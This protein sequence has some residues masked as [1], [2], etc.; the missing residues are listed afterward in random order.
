ML[1]FAAVRAA[2][3]KVD[4]T[5]GGVHDSNLFR[6]SAP[7][8]AL[9]T[10]GGA[11]DIYS[12]SAGVSITSDH[13]PL[14]IAAQLAATRS[15]FA[16]NKALANTGYAADVALHYRAPRASVDVDG[17]VVRRLANFEDL[18]STTSGSLQTL[19]G[20]TLEAT[21][22]VLG[23]V[24]LI[25]GAGFQRSSNSNPALAIADYNR[26]SAHGGI[27]YYSPTGNILAIEGSMVRATG[28]NDRQSTVGG[29]LFA[30]RASFSEQTAA[31]HLFYSPSVLWQIDTRIGYT[32]HKDKSGVA[33]DYS[34]LTGRLDAR[35]VP[36]EA[37][38][39]HAR[40]SRD[41]QTSSG[42][43][44]NG[45]KAS[46][47]MLEGIGQ[48]SPRLTLTLAATRRYRSF[49]YDLQAPLTLAG[50]KERIDE[51]RLTIGYTP[52]YRF[53]LLFDAARSTRHSSSAI[54]RYRDTQLT[55]TLVAHFGPGAHPKA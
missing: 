1:P 55:A 21:R 48:A 3:I 15:W 43:F 26:L 34:G 33:G 42:V 28:L 32:R 5:A 25:G 45:V 7:A 46:Q 39:L 19:S 38:Q 44:S 18:R 16:H 41:F 29:T 13:D 27:G 51:G 37:L 36:R 30:Y 20:A 22:S 14:S 6:L 35:W 24:R 2:E 54:F 40:L 47:I 17:N 4:L 52:S 23:D 12:A 50:H 53:S 10:H 49:R 31:L 11:D 8:R 9:A